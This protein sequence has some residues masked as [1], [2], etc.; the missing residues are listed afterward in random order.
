MPFDVDG[1]VPANSL[2]WQGMSGA[3]VRGP[4]IRPAGPGVVVNVDED[5]QQRRLYV[6]SLPDPAT[7]TAF[8]AALAEVGAEPVL[9]AA[10]APAVRRLLAA[11]DQRGRPPAV[12]QVTQLD[13]F[14]ARKARTDI[15]T[16]DNPY[17]PYVGRQLDRDIAKALD[18]RA[19][20]A[21]RR[22]LLLVG[23]TMTG[24]SRTGA[25][26]LQAHPA[27]SARPLL[28]PQHEADCGRSS[29]L[30]PRAGRCSGSTTSTPS[31]TG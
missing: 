20:G 6:A 8:S 31:L 9:E 25:H 11:W 30:H 14:G 24:K 4:A 21:E 28:V 27:L 12:G 7:D 1:S 2:L 3:A 18:R 5:R 22:V 13:V 10:N 17:Y 16:H 23:E 19:S 15:D 29:S 26:A